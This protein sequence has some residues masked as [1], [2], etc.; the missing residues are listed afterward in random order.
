LT[1]PS[2]QKTL[3]GTL[4]KNRA[5]GA[6]RRIIV[7]GVVQGVGF[8]PFVH[9]LATSLNLKGYVLNTSR[10]VMIDVESQEPERVGVF[11]ERLPREI[12]PLALVER[13]EVASIDPRGYEDFTIRA[14]IDE[15]D[16]YVLISPDIAACDDCLREMRDPRDRRHDYAFI[17]CTNCGPR[18]SIIRDTPYDRPKTTMAAF[19]MCAACQREYADPTDRRFHAQPVACPECGPSVRLVPSPD[20]AERFQAIMEPQAALRTARQMLRQGMVLAVRGLGGFQIACDA[21]SHE[22]VARL[23]TAK[24]RSNKPFAVMCR[25]LQV[26][27]RYAR[28]TTEEE[29]VLRGVRKPICLVPLREDHEPLSPLVAPGNQYLGVMLPYTPLH[30]LLFADGPDVLVM[31]SGNWSEEPIVTD[32]QEAL[33]RLAPL[34]DG[35]LLHNRDICTRVDDSVVR[36]F[37][38]M[39]RLIRRAR[40]Y[41][42]SPIDLGKRF[43][44]ILA[45]GGE[46]KHTFCLTKDRFAIMSQHI[47]DL[48]NLESMRFFL[49]TLEN[50]KKLYRVTPAAVAYDLHPRYLSTQ[51]AQE[52]GDLP[53]VGVQHHH[54]HVAACMAEHHVEGAVIGVAFDG[55]GYGDDGTLWGGEILVADRSTYR[56][57]AHLKYLPLPGGESAVREPWRMAVSYLVT[58]Y[59][60]LPEDVQLSADRVSVRNVVGLVRSG[61]HAPATSSVGRLFDAVS[62]LLGIRQRITFEGEA[63]MEMHSDPEAEG[64]YP[65]EWNAADPMV[66]DPSPAIRGLK[67]DRDR[68]VSVSVLGGRFHRS[69]A[70]TVAEVCRVVRE[71]TG[72][73]RV[74]LTGGV[75]QNMLLLRWTMEHLEDRGFE[76]YAHERV[77]TNDGGIALGQAA[78]AAARLEGL[79]R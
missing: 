6:A 75:F 58:V 41:V 24:R 44:E 46:L 30:E 69:L 36:V 77:P 22:A 3:I 9:N 31:T 35:F 28:L 25:D 20:R 71:R 56:R 5:A 49:E 29:Q 14:S 76:V 52:Q 62:S 65:F 23:R 33:E 60:D 12:P 40:G 37:R 73:N 79:G 48:E 57:A 1:P 11:I 39:E 4:S 45:C 10:G 47:G 32:N 8:R 19:A 16:H 53:G 21:A 43:P 55:T 15:P 68:G 34:V 64:H 67:R 50:L 51:W 59:G 78:V 63:A 2:V 7:T 18:Y 17:N 13:I 61:R 74:C 26:V 66:L 72:L 27:H 42:P 54:A 70:I 38:G